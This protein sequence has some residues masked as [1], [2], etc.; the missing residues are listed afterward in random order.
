MSYQPVTAGDPL[1]SSG[2]GGGTPYSAADDDDNLNDDLTEQES[3]TLSQI[4]GE[5]VDFGVPSA[6]RPVQQD[7]SRFASLFAG[8]TNLCGNAK[9]LVCNLVEVGRDSYRDD[10]RN[11]LK[12]T[13]LCSFAILSVTLITVFATGGRD[14]SPSSLPVP[15]PQGPTPAPTVDWYAPHPP[16]PPP[17][18]APPAPPGP[19]VPPAPQPPAPPAPPGPS[20]DPSP[21]NPD[22]KPDPK[23]DC[24]VPCPLHS[25]ITF[26]DPVFFKQ[27]SKFDDDDDVNDEYTHSYY[28]V[29]GGDRLSINW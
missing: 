24:H 21:P 23:P 1:A 15:V 7:K 29:G 10:P 19:P 22:P 4:A 2:G 18:P 8:F 12:R 13:G 27:F 5:T 17:P 16:P 14:S 26:G 6:Y 9:V 25:N 20:P 3:M 11:F 28:Q